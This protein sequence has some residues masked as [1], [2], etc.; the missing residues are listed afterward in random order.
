MVSTIKWRPIGDD[1]VDR[2]AYAIARAEG[3]FVD[4]SLPQRLNNPGDL[5]DPTT[6]KLRQFATPAEGWDALR[7]QVRAMLS[8][9]S[10]WYRPDMTLLEVAQRYTGGDNPQGW[11]QVIAEEFGVTP[12]TKLGELA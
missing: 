11:A 4:G 7:R 10:V 12:N 8:G 9:M 3:Y 1:L 6:G 5:V 2:L